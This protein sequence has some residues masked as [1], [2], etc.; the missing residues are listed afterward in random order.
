MH[1]AA[2]TSEKLL[3]RLALRVFSGRFR[4]KTRTAIESSLA[5]LRGLVERGQGDSHLAPAA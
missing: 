1:F 4:S 5:T 3:P 2:P